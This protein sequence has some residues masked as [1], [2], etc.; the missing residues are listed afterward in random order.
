MD[1]EES[2]ASERIRAN[3]ANLRRRISDAAARAGR[4][5]D[6]IQIVAVTKGQPASVIRAASTAGL[7]QFGENYV[8]EALAKQAELADFASARWH[9]IGHLQRNKADEIVNSFALLQSVDSERL[10][11]RLG[12]IAENRGVIQDVLVQ[13]RLGDEPTKFGVPREEAPALC[14]AVLKTPGLR[15]KGLMGIA[16]RGSD[17]RPHFAL[18]RSLFEQLPADRRLVLSMGMSADFE[19]AIEEGATM[20]RI[21][22][23]LLGRRHTGHLASPSNL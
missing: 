21:G 2:R 20:V 10:A 9:F 12:S 8:Q 13:M 11:T 3:L 23:A 14:E 16:P 15:L 18:L 19:A 4:A 6:D 1:T 17:P 5:G 7:N 22:E